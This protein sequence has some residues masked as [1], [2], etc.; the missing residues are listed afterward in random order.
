MNRTEIISNLHCLNE[1][2]LVAINN[3]LVDQLKSVRQRKSAL[4]R[5]LFSSGDTVGFGDRAG[6]GKR[7]YKEG[8][9]SRVKRTRAEVLVGNTTWTVPLNMLTAV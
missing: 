6:R 1:A 2:D 7:A 9:I 8:T 5:H 4:A 3:A